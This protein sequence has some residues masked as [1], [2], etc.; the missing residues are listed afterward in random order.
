EWFEVRFA[1]NG[2]GIASKA[3]WSCDEQA[4]I[5]IAD[6][7]SS[8]L[9]TF[10]G[11]SQGDAPPITVK[12]VDDDLWVVDIDISDVHKMIDAQAHSL[13]D[14]DAGRRI[15]L[16][17]QYATWGFINEAEGLF[18]TLRGQVEGETADY[19]LSRELTVHQL[20]KA[21]ALAAGRMQRAITLAMLLTTPNK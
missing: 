16:V 19:I 8:E 7:A 13:N 5:C 15:G 6:V 20:H 18:D 9:A 11:A 10:L 3:A 1:S 2:D 14:A 17:S 12:Q 4:S 21:K